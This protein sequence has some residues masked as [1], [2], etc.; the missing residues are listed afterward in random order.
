MMAAGLGVFGLAGYLFVTLT[1]RT[2]N[3]SQANLAVNFYFVLNIVGP[4][5]FY[6]LEQVTSRS[7]S[8]AVATG[9]TLRPVVRRMATGG[10]GLTAAVVAGLLLMSPYVLPKTLGGDS[11]LFLGILAT[12]V[13][14]AVLSLVRGVLGGLQRFTG[15]AAT[16]MVE[17]GAR[18]AVCVVLVA[19]HA[20]SAWM[21]G[22]GFLLSS[23]VAAASGWFWLR[24][25]PAG[26]PGEVPAVAK[27][28][29]ALAVANLLAQLLPN[30]APLVVSSRL[31]AESV[32]ALT[33][34]QAVVIARIPMLAFFPIQTMLLPALTTAVAR[35]DFGFVRRRITLT[36]GAVVAVGAVYA[37]A[38]V[39]LGPWVL[40]TFMATRTDLDT[41]VLVLLAVSTV[42]LIAAF[43]VQPALVALGKDRTITIGWGVGTA[44]TMALAV[45]PFD[46]PTVAAAAQVVGPATTLLVVLFGLRRALARR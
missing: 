43:A 1:G 28:L 33:F 4:G 36:L 27:A 40:R 22:V 12:P 41:L 42:V 44:I 23:L 29:A 15:Y 26:S 3:T 34:A 32:V 19:A 5:I 35:G 45:V 24:P 14:L 20:P 38:F 6:A 25:A 16:L 17:G 46:A 21:F 37:L 10:A 30:L 9:Q 31:G 18:L 8:A 11:A 2:L 13:V 39:G 7:V